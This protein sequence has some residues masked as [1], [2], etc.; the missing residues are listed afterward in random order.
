MHNAPRKWRLTVTDVS[1]SVA[2][3]VAMFGP[4]PS[5]AQYRPPASA[6]V[7]PVTAAHGG[8]SRREPVY[9]RSPL[10]SEAIQSP[11]GVITIDQAVQLGL[12]LNR[13]LALA[14]EALHRSSG[15]LA[16][17]RAAGNPT[18]GA[19]F[20]YTRLNTG[21]TINFSGRNIPI[22]NADQ[23]VF[24]AQVTLPVDI[25][26]MIRTAADQARFTEIAARLDVNRSRNQVVYDVK[27]AYY[28]V[29]RARALLVVAKQNV[30][31][32]E[33]RQL[34]AQQKLTAGTVARFDLIRAQTDVANSRQQQIA[35]DSLV[36]QDI[37]QLN[38]A[39]GVDINS[40]TKVTEA[41]SVTDLPP[42]PGQPD[43]PSAPS[44]AGTKQPP[45]Q[46]SGSEYT[47]LID[48]ALST[49][50]DVLQAD[51][52]IA[53]AQKGVRLARR[54]QLPTLGV[55]LA[56]TVN[57]NAAGFAPQTAGGQLVV[58]LSA[59][60]FDGGVARARVAQARADV[61]TAVIG[62]RQATDLA[63]LE[64]RGAWLSLLQ[65]KAQ[66]SVASQAL[67]QAREG[68]R[69]ARVRYNAGVSGTAGLSPQ[70]EVSD[71]QAALTQAET[72]RVNALY[73]V[74]TASAAL[75][76]AVGRYSYAAGGEGFV[77]PP[78]VPVERLQGVKR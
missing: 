73:A 15:R 45:D 36:S 14:G 61:E 37:G 33:A 76:R 35:A 20:T 56:G 6:S 63:S 42:A 57:P 26:G 16:E 19:G 17:A 21:Q 49:R 48:E 3:I 77:A 8:E 64:V 59:P 70:L 7:T 28:E 27:A 4:T 65:A 25:A 68:F 32:A 1:A 29:L 51:A 71:A 10:L 34:D 67:A 58:G 52:N 54:T 53:A 30:Q 75:D 47:R 46:L 11:D 69:L 66:V 60:L 18:A 12:R 55:T 50:P 31:N 38:S 9:V 13:S 23:P 39:M 62:R 44:N 43:S 5:M 72:N 74:N 22:V 78:V 40:D 41:G 24:S 2:A